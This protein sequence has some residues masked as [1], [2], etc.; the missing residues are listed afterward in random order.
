MQLIYLNRFYLEWINGRSIEDISKDIIEYYNECEQRLDGKSFICIDTEDSKERVIMRLVNYEKNMRILKECPHLRLNDLAVTY[1]FVISN[2]S[3]NGLASARIDYN[4]I[5]FFNLTL[6]DLNKYALANTE[7]LFPP[8]FE[9]M[10]TLMKRYMRKRGF[11]DTE[12]YISEDKVPMYV[13][14]TAEAL[15]GAVCILYKGMLE[16][17]PADTCCVSLEVSLIHQI[18]LVVLCANPL[19]HK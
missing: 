10:E 14:T 17:L 5:E 19:L 12:R 18:S 9:K 2:D 7:R 1:H 6:D 11:L 8:V 15:N 4:N 3:E 13:L 16:A